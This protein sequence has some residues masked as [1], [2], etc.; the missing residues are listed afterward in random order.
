MES[1]AVYGLGYVGLPLAK[2][3]K[4][5]GYGVLGVDISAA[6]VERARK[7]GVEAT[8]DGVSAAKGADIM[9]VCVP[10]PVD[11]AYMPDLGPVKSACGMLASGLGKG[12]LVIVESTINPGVMEGVVRPILE[13]TGLKAGRDFNLAHCPERIDPGNRRYGVHNLPRVVGGITAGCAS[14]AAVFYRSIIDA[15]VLEL[16]SIKA[17]EATKIM[18]N[19]F[20]DVNIAFINEMAKSFDSLGIDVTEVIRA[21]STKPFGF[22]PHYPGA[23]VGGHCIP[24]DPYYLIEEAKRRGFNHRFLL[25]AREINNGMPEYVVQ[26]VVDGL[27]EVGLSVK[28]AGVCVLG[29]AYKRDVDDV[30]ESPSVKIIDKLK[31]LGAKVEVYDPFIPGRSTL[32]G[33]GDCMASDC[34]VLVTDHSEYVKMDYG[35]LGEVKVVVDGRNCLDKGKIEAAGVVYRGIGRGR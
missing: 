5:K 9:V 26:K 3:A 2:L 35:R 25:L 24:V 11:E 13:E 34:L 14:K 1:V 4:S 17:A 12:K 30:R 7:E 22:M 29:V 8:A 28:G 33:L 16:S 10:T 23:G 31:K 20:R 18:E 21:A 19:S 15:D 6:A 32:K 27:N